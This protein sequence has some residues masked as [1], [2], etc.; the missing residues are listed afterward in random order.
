MGSLI[1]MPSVREKALAERA[2]TLSRSRRGVLEV[3]AAELQRLERDLHDGA[4]ARLVSRGMN[5]G[6]AEDLLDTDPML[7]APLS[8]LSLTFATW[9]K[10]SNRRCWPTMGSRGH[11]RSGPD[12]PVA[13][14]LELDLPRAGLP[15]PGR[16]GHVFCRV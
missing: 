10:V 13:I 9:S 4:Q 16:V 3:H 6:M 14:D 7:A 8:R 1:S 15:A 2:G 11:P 12:V 5:L